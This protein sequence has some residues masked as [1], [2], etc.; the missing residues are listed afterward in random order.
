MREAAE[1]EQH[2]A[3]EAPKAAVP[4]VAPAVGRVLA[5]QRTIG[6][7]AVTRMLQRTPWLRHDGRFFTSE[8]CMEPRPFVNAWLEFYGFDIPAVRNA[9]RPILIDGQARSM[10]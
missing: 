3:E 9:A 4:G 7:A 10:E 1:R 2:V 6:N 8:L 5:L